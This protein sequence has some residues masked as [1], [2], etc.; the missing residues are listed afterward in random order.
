MFKA[1]WLKAEKD[2]FNSAN[3]THKY[4]Q[5]VVFL[6]KLLNTPLAIS[7]NYAT[8]QTGD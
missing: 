1:F 5:K 2:A 7:L 4:Y 8:N 6:N 3:T